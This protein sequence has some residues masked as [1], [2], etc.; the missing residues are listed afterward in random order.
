MPPSRVLML[1]ENPR[2]DR[3]I[4]R[5][6]QDE[7]NLDSNWGD[8]DIQE[9]LFDLLLLDRIHLTK[10]ST[11]IQKL[12]EDAH[13]VFL[14]SLLLLPLKTSRIPNK[15]LGKT[16]DDV[17]IHPFV[18]DELNARVKNLLRIRRMSQDLKKKHDQVARLSVTDDVSGFHNS[19]Y[20]HRHL[21]RLLAKNAKDKREHSLV[22]FDIDD[23]KSVVDSHGHLLGAKTLKEIAEA[24]HSCLNTHDR[25]VRYGGDEFVVILPRQSKA[26]A[27]RKTVRIKE[28]VANTPYLQKEGID[29]H[30]TASF[31]VATFPEDAEDKRSLLA[32]ADQCLFESKDHGKN[33]I[34]VQGRDADGFIV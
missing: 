19:R 23:F 4:K 28:R 18:K 12:R 17:L 5:F 31:G 33:R 26:E 1:I 7:C 8:C 20:L 15:L 32:Q 10:H 16:V 2:F 25:I 21:D 13:P 30:L 3:M 9:E 14:P 34:K 22:F 6:L 11:Q 24:V 29:L 27:I